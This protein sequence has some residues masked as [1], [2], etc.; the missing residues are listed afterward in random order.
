[1]STYG[2]SFT[3]SAHH[4]APDIVNLQLQQDYQKE[5]SDSNMEAGDRG[6]IR[7]AK[8]PRISDENENYNMIEQ[9]PSFTGRLSRLLGAQEPQSLVGLPDIIK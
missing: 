4:P 6:E 3:L 1:M 8:R 9:G 2:S 5:T 7:S